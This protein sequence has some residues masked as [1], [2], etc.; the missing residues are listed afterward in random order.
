M[1][2]F[3]TGT[4]GI[5]DI[6]GGVETHCE[7]LYPLISEKGHDVL[8]ATRSSYVKERRVAWIRVQLVQSF[9][10]KTKSLEAIVHTFIS[11]LKARLHNPDIVHIHAVGPALL[12][13]FAR[14]LGMKVVFTDHGP[15]YERQK[16]GKLAKFVL[17]LG[18]KWGGSCANEVIVISQVIKKIITNRCK[19][20]SNLIYNGV[21]IPEIS[22]GNDFLN[23][24][25]VTPKQY[26]LAVARF[27]A[28][29]GTYRPNRCFPKVRF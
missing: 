16:W 18:E 14:L 21:T 8:V 15:D 6:P 4:R 19:R 25:G 13:P 9:S 26:L 12:V 27:C 24:I 23:R 5:P 1:K 3:V 22:G 11:L 10:P 7:H 2:I 28:G 17:R 20:E 29:K